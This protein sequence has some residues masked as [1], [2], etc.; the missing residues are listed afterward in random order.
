MTY[1]I[2]A[3]ANGRATDSAEAD[4]YEENVPFYI[5]EPFVA[6]LKNKGYAVVVSEE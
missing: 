3:Y 1:T 2:Y 6:E 5:M 4:V